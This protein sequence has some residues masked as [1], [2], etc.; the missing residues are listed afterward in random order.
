[1]S[2]IIAISIPLLF[3]FHTVT[4]ATE[5]AT[6]KQSK[7]DKLNEAKRLA[8]ESDRLYKQGRYDEA[9]P[10]VERWLA[11][12]ENV[13]GPEDHNVATV[14]NNLAY[15]YE[16]KGDY[17]KAEPL[18]Q[19]ALAINEKALGPQHPDVAQSLN[20]LGTLYYNQGDYAKAE[21]FLQRALA[22]DEK[23][24]GLQHPFVATYLNNLAA[25]YFDKGDYVKAEPLYQR[26]LA[27]REKTLGPEHSDV[28]RL[29][30]NLAELYRA[31]G[32]YTKAEPLFQRSLQIKE[33]SLGPEHP[34]IATTLNNL[35]ALYEAQNITAK[36]VARRTQAT[37]I[38]E[39]NIVLNLAIGSERQKLLFLDGYSRET[40]DVISLHIRSAPSDQSALRLALTTV[41]RRKGRALDAMAESIAALRRRLNP[42]QQNLL[43]RLTAE[44]RRSK[45]SRPVH[46]HQS[47]RR[48]KRAGNSH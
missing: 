20:N 29:L 14:L 36:A 15:L 47:A 42:E 10:L 21:P 30:N 9:I 39:H 33:K 18:F 6:T 22:V 44:R 43:D 1:L 28:A 23:A 35:A 5:P 32:G 41:L 37:N 19:R 11:I 24:L 3:S 13:L 7:S 17:T 25:L 34:D 27:I 26:A 40:N 4:A 48:D 46:S 12:V 2:S 38:S 45:K 16:E 31:K 8:E